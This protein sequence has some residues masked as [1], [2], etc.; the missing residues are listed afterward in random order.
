MRLVVQLVAS[1]T[2]S[3]GAGLAVSTLPA[4]APVPS[5]PRGCGC[6]QALED[7]LDTKKAVAENVYHTVLGEVAAW[8]A[9]WAAAWVVVLLG[10]LF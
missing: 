2:T 6:W 8:V 9:A 5:V 3:N 7:Y 1:C 10:L 4:A